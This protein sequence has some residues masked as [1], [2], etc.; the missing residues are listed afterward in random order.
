MFHLDTSDVAT[1]QISIST[2]ISKKKTS[3]Q[4]ALFACSFLND[5]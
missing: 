4:G 3:F 2:H 1:Y 5:L